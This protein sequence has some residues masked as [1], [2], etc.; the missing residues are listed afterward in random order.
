MYQPGTATDA[1]DLLQ[2]IVAFLL[3]N[4][5]TQ[6]MSQAEGNGWRAHLNRS[7]VYVNLRALVTTESTAYFPGSSVSTQSTGCA[8]IAVNL[9]TG[10]SSSSSWF[11]QAGTP[12]TSTYNCVSALDMLNSTTNYHLFTDGDN[13]LV[14]VERTTGIFQWIGWG[15]SLTKAGSWT[16]GAYFGG[17]L[18]GAYNA[19]S[20]LTSAR[21]GYLNG[22]SFTPYCNGEGVFAATYVASFVRA[23][24]DTFTGKW[25]GIGSITSTGIPTQNTGKIGASTIGGYNSS[26]TYPPTLS[27][28]PLSDLL[29]ARSTSTLTGGFVLIPIDL[30]AN[31]DTATVG[32]GYSLL[33]TVPMVYATN[34]VGNGYVAGQ[35]VSIG[36]DTYVLFPNFAVKI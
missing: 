27:S 18:A 14:V 15:I 1:K 13:V 31:R 25:V 26:G 8:G 30:Y 10:Y 17:T 16:G 7:G 20:A 22:S 36:A 11:A 24:V 2:K 9:G 35:Q 32:G 33:G 23:D 19:L 6:N 4:G 5:W 28:I 29:R 21:A 34:A 12:L 3:S